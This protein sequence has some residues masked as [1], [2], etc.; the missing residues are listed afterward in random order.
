MTTTI[1]IMILVDAV[2]LVGFQKSD[3][4]REP[5]QVG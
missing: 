1:S 2:H 4:L 3:I 5:F